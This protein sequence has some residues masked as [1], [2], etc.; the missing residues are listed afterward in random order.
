[1]SEVVG[2]HPMVTIGSGAFSGAQT[3]SLDGFPMKKHDVFRFYIYFQDF[4]GFL[5]VFKSN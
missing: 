4:C 1:M 2:S 5:G 3:T